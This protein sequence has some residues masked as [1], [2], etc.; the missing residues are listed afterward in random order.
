MRAPS[1]HASL[2]ML[3]APQMQ[4]IQSSNEHS[5]HRT[6]CRTQSLPS[7]RRHRGQAGNYHNQWN[8]LLPSFK[9]P[10]TRMTVS[11]AQGWSQLRADC[12]LCL[13]RAP[14]RN[15]SAAVP[16]GRPAPPTR[17]SLHSCCSCPQGQSALAPSTHPECSKCCS[18]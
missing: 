1:P 3:R 11:P 7:D 16:S 10:L 8:T 17:S 6:R 5:R 13:T 14:E 9:V 15:R 4:E 18:K 2:G 12:P